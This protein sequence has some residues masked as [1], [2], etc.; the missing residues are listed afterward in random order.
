MLTQ[1]PTGRW[2]WFLVGLELAAK[3]A[4][5]ESVCLFWL[6]ERHR[7]PQFRRH[8]SQTAQSLFVLLPL[9]AEA[10]IR[11]NLRFDASTSLCS[12]NGNQPKMHQQT[13]EMWAKGSLALSLSFSLPLFSLGWCESI[14]K[15]RPPSGYHEGF[16]F[17]MISSGYISIRPAYN[18]EIMRWNVKGF[19]A[20]RPRTVQSFGGV[21]V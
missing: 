15:T 18:G 9:E 4:D 19:Q 20:P 7:A 16:F 5:E 2:R 1:W 13:R 3:A 17:F 14:R 10:V 8:T 11:H 12:R 6:C 21:S